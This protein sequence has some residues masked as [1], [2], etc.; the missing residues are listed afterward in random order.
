MNRLRADWSWFFVLVLIST[1][2]KFFLNSSAQLFLV[3]NFVCSRFVCV[4]VCFENPRSFFLFVAMGSRKEEERN[5]KIIRGLMKL[6]PNR[7]CINCNGLVIGNFLFF[8]FLDV[9]ENDFS[10]NLFVSLDSSLS[11]AILSA[12]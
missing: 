4:T 5:E 7:R 12:F 3:G 2:P 9:V 10:S 11:F 1:T 6:P 8:L